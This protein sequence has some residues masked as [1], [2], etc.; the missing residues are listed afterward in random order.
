AAEAPWLSLP[1]LLATRPGRTSAVGDAPMPPTEHATTITIP[2]ILAVT[3]LLPGHAD[4]SVG[5]H[6][7]QMI[8]GCLFSGKGGCLQ[9]RAAPTSPAGYFTKALCFA[10]AC[11]G[12]LAHYL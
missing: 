7:R 12:C 1:R 8:S 9:C 10:R 3:I 4:A 6:R 11:G 5:R 2:D